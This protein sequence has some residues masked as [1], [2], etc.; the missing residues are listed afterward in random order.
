MI[1]KIDLSQWKEATVPKKEVEEMT[2]ALSDAFAMIL[3]QKEKEYKFAKAI[4]YLSLIVATLL[5]AKEVF[6]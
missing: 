4:S 2:Q 3:Q 6:F 1:P 5:I